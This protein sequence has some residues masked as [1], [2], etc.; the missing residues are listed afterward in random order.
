MQLLG[1]RVPNGE[2]RQGGDETSSPQGRD[3]PKVF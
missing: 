2:Q 3:G 1:A